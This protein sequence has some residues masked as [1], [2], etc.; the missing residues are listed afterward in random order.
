VIRCQENTKIPLD[1]IAQKT[2]YQEGFSLA[3]LEAMATALPVVISPQCRF[4]EVARVGAGWVVP[5]TVADTAHAILSFGRMEP[6]ERNKIAQAARNLVCANYG[7]ET[8]LDKTLAL[9]SSIVPQF[10]AIA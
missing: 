5:N 1:G 4:Q 3:V 10:S 9:Y 6:Q 2:S 7:W 8:I